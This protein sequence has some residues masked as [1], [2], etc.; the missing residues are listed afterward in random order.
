MK[1]KSFFQLNRCL[2]CYDK[3][4]SFADISFGDCYI[5]EEKS[6]YGKSNVIIRTNIG[7]KIYEKY[8]YLF[9][10]NKILLTQ[11]IQSHHQL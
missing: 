2:F 9:S 8:S 1:L 5:K 4:N 3:L 10:Y 11:I 6:F 7:K